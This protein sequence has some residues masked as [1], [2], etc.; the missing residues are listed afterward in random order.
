M[1]FDLDGTVLERM[2]AHYHARLPL[3]PGA[4][5]VVQ[6]LGRRDRGL[7]QRAP[8]GRY[9]RTEGARRAQRGLSRPPPV[10]WHWLRSS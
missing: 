10:H 6:R 9:S 3:Y 8:L 5:E 1:V 4:L 7:Q 2:A